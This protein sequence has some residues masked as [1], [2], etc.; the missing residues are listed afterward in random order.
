[1]AY[2]NEHN[3]NLEERILILIRGLVDNQHI[4]L[5]AQELHRSRAWLQ[6]VQKIQRCNER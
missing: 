3:A 4:E 5:I 1:M 2:K 6:M